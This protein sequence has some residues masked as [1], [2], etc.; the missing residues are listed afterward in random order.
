MAFHQT[1]GYQH[2]DMTDMG[3]RCPC[4]DPGNYVL[5]EIDDLN[6]TITCWCGRRKTGQ[7]DDEDDRANF[8]SR[9][10]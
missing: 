10:E 8:I 7:F 1:I 9:H 4:W 6:V 2:Q 5:I 3:G